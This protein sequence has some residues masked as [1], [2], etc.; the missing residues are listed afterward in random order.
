MR[1]IISASI[2]SVLLLYITL[3]AQTD[4]ERIAVLNLEAVGVSETESMTLT[5]RLRSELMRTQSFMI[6]E[7]SKMAE[8]L[9]EQGFQM[10]GCTT[11]ECAVEAG[12]L[13]NV[14]QICVGSV[15][16]SGTLYTILVR[17]I[18]VETGTLVKAVNYD[19]KGTLQD[20]ST[21]Y[22]RLV[23]YKL[24]GKL[25]QL[26]TRTNFGAVTR[27]L[28][29][30]GWG[31]LYQEKNTRA[32]FY[33][34]SF[35]LSLG[36]SVW[37]TQNY[38]K[39]IKKYENIRFQYLNTFDESEINML[40]KKM[41]QAYDD[42]LAKEKIRNIFYATAAAIWFINIMDALFLPPRWEKHVRLSAASNAGNVLAG[43][44]IYF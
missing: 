32:L 20:L 1:K 4:K 15:V 34:Y 44:K 38:N 3:F 40:R 23:A 6:L 12:R 2:L 41:D 16:K 33:Q 17:L 7:Q 36:S 26:N 42:I 13:L 21:I 30:P 24:A 22:I 11:N 39:S 14:R 5:D 25:T 19:I 37:S 27:S 43:V 9:E 10:T 29:M 8:I 28:V 18:D 31:Q 35:L